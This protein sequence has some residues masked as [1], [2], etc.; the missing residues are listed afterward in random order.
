MR[1]AAA[2]LGVTQKRTPPLCGMSV[3][4]SIRGV[5]S[6]AVKIRRDETRG[7]YHDNI[8]L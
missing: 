7:E 3:P 5:C 8:L 2:C 4:Q 6:Q 1:H